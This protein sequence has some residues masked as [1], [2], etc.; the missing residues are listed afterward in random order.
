[1]SWTQHKLSLFLLFDVRKKKV[2]F[3]GNINKRL[4]YRIKTKQKTR[5]RTYVISKPSN[6]FFPPSLHPD[7]AREENVSSLK[8]NDKSMLL[9]KKPIAI[10][11]EI[12]LLASFFL[13]LYVYFYTRSVYTLYT[14]TFSGV[15]SMGKA[16]VKASVTHNT[17]VY[18]VS[19]Q[20]QTL[21]G[22]CFSV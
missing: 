18:Y 5:P 14:A 15:N 7:I 21:N 6:V 11:Y 3:Q 20:I 12:F 19:E 10:V 16:F 2:K 1:M 13:T 8:F 22:F 4:T 17:C 9:S